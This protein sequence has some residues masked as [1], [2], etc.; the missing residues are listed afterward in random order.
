MMNKTINY[1]MN[2]IWLQFWWRFMCCLTHYWPQPMLIAIMMF[3]III[4]MIV[5]MCITIV[6]IIKYIMTFLTILGVFIKPFH[7][8]VMESLFTS[9]PSGRF[10]THLGKKAL[11]IHWEMPSKQHQQGTTAKIV[12][13]LQKSRKYQTR[14][15]Q[16]FW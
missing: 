1:K 14:K 4:I 12:S 2:T 5:T 11:R 16:H 9:P 6:I 7:H 15:S 3:I 10:S 13:L 8:G